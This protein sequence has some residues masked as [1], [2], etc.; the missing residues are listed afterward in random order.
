MKIS[1]NYFSLAILVLLLFLGYFNDP[2]GNLAAE[3]LKRY[4]KE[5]ISTCAIKIC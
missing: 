5:I 3:N 2:L 1:N 4:K